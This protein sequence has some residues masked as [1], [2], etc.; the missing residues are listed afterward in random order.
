MSHKCCHVNNRLFFR[1]HNAYNEFNEACCPYDHNFAGA[2]GRFY[3][4]GHNG[5]CIKKSEGFVGADGA[6]PYGSVHHLSHLGRQRGICCTMGA[7]D[8][9]VQHKPVRSEDRAGHECLFYS[10]DNGA[11]LLAAE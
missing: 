2:C 5:R 4:N 11:F 9:A 6:D 8:T 10:A 3:R 1:R 7:A